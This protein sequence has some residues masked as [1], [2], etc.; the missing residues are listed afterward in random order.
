MTNETN[1]MLSNQ[2]KKAG[3]L[4]QCTTL[5]FPYLKMHGEQGSGGMLGLTNLPDKYSRITTRSLPFKEQNP[6]AHAVVVAYCKNIIENVGRGIGFYFYSI[7]NAENPRGTGTGKTTA[8]AAIINEYVASRVVEH[9]KGTRPILSRPALFVRAVELQNA[10]NAQ[11]RGTIDMQQLASQ[12]YYSMKKNM[13]EVELLAIDDIGLREATESF[14]TEFYEILDDRCS[15]GRATLF[16]S[17]TPLKDIPQILSAQIASR[18]D[19]MTSGISFIGKDHRKG[20]N[21]R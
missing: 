2:C 9:M 15:E 7:P 13:T 12:K 21:F 17:N 10:F 16:S 11:F 14:T 8:S 6:Q 19:G 3:D 5:C 1:C 20:G 4:Q 18:I